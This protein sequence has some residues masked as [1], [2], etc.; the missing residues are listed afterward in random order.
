MSN[1]KLNKLNSYADN[2]KS[3]NKVKIIIDVEILA[4]IFAFILEDTDINPYK[5]KKFLH[6]LKKLFDCM[7]LNYY[8]NKHEDL[9]YIN[10]IKFIVDKMIVE[11]VTSLE[12]I[13]EGIKEEYPEYKFI[14]SDI[15]AVIDNNYEGLST[16]TEDERKFVTKF[17]E[18][19]L[20]NLYMFRARDQLRP[21]F[22]KMD[23]DEFLTKLNEPFV[24]IVSKMYSDCTRAK[25]EQEA[26]FNDFD[27]MDISSADNIIEK[28]VDDYT[29][30]NNRIKTGIKSFNKMLNGGFENSRCYMILGA[31]K[32]FKS[33]ILL[34]IVSWGLRYNKFKKDGDKI[35]TIFYCTMEN[36]VRETINRIYTHLTGKSIAKFSKKEAVKILN[37][38]IRNK[39]G[40]NLVIRF[41][42]SKTIN[43][44]ELDDMI[45]EIESNGRKV[46]MLVMDYIKKIRSSNPDREE[47][48]ELANVVDDF[49]NI[50][51]TR[52]IVV[53]SAS[54]L[55]REA[56]KI[57][58]TAIEKGE[59]DIAK[60]LH[61]SHVGNSV[62]IIE[63]ADVSILINKE[64]DWLSFKL[65][66]SRDEEN[67]TTYFVQ[68][69]E[70]GM[71]LEEDYDLDRSLSRQSVSEGDSEN[72]N[73]NRNDD[74]GYEDDEEKKEK[75]VRK[76]GRKRSTQPIK[77]VTNTKKEGDEEYE[78]EELS[79]D[80]D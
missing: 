21:I 5:S 22:E 79:F 49:C 59:T 73:P 70:N 18:S 56:L 3:N 72:F 37:D 26:A 54:Q 7:D 47:R 39:Y 23:Y 63:N 4:T 2:K 32:S 75:K 41:R 58:E 68:K 53:V 8:E 55:N 17:I 25:A 61:S 42:P 46:V 57:I 62:G 14:I 16:I 19:R 15:K 28:T 27:L 76:K 78:D 10:T 9:T 51:K 77:K 71:K 48:I 34:N 67:D 64:D 11:K 65:L 66:R 44:L 69:F 38:E 30:P 6:N 33:G 45:T 29:R 74:E 50:A 60:A 40:V 36:S 31:P 12:V 43:T 13:L 35:P 80:D 24:D 1:K 20:I 52:N